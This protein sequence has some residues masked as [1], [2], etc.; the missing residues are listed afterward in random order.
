LTDINR[1]IAEFPD[2]IIIL[3]IKPDSENAKNF[4]TYAGDK[5]TDMLEY[6]LGP[7]I[8]RFQLSLSGDLSSYNR[9]KSLNQSVIIL[10]DFTKYH[11][12]NAS[13]IYW[14]FNIHDSKWYNTDKISTL[15]KSCVEKIDTINSNSKKIVVA[16]LVL[17]PNIDT[18]IN[19][20]IPFDLFDKYPDNIKELSIIVNKN[21]SNHKL[22]YDVNYNSKITVYL[23]DFPSATIINKIIKLNF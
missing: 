20:I 1:F 5:L 18:V 11:N 16:Q 10:Y 14:P 6:I 8:H 23:L 9:I 22:I 3:A 4:N 13:L 12:S 2:E 21:I 7:H 17:T 19:S 15:L